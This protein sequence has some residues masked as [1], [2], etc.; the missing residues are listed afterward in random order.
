MGAGEDWGLWLAWQE[1]KVPAKGGPCWLPDQR[2]IQRDHGWRGS[3]GPARLP[4]DGWRA[5]GQ[6]GRQQG[7]QLSRGPSLGPQDRDRQRQGQRQGQGQRE[8]QAR[9]Q[10]HWGARPLIAPASWERA[11]GQE[12]RPTGLRKGGCEAKVPARCPWEAPTIQAGGL[13]R[14]GEG[15]AGHLWG[16]QIGRAH[17]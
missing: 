12:Q 9:L 4:L 1:Q 15:A 16:V 13:G 6:R 17:V 11:D 5:G 8:W 3:P 2:P 7:W 14:V 10:E